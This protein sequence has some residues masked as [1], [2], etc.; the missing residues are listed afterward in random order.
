[1][2]DPNSLEGRQTYLSLKLTCYKIHD[3][4]HVCM[5]RGAYTNT[6]DQAN[7]QCATYEKGSWDC[8]KQL[9]QKMHIFRIEPILEESVQECNKAPGILIGEGSRYYSAITL[10]FSDG[11][12]ESN[13][14][15]LA[16]TLTFYG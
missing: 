14:L 5:H 4:I 16:G 15:K 1:M 6:T 7:G 11:P 13:F 8:E 9:H 12:Y 2:H 10:R 3:I